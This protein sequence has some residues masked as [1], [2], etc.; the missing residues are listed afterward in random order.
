M[1]SVRTPN[2]VSA[3]SQIAAGV[4]PLLQ[5]DMNYYD[6]FYDIRKSDTATKVAETT[7]DAYLRTSGEAAGI[8]AYGQVCD[9]LVNW[10][11]QE[12][13]IPQI[14]VV[15]DTFDPYDETQVDLSGNVNARS[16]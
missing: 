7:N 9:L 13:V 3:A 6:S 12:I 10:H 5:R 15:E 2:A 16:A 11:I 1:C 8:A 4:S 14:A